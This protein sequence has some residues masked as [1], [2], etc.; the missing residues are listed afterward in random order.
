MKVV[1]DG[2]R[3]PAT[4]GRNVCDRETTVFEISCGT[5]TEGMPGVGRCGDELGEVLEL[6]V[7]PLLRTMSE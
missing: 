6:L 2:I 5:M 3:C 4:A 7:A 1:E